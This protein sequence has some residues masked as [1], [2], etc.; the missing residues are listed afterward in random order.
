MPINTIKSRQPNLTPY[1]FPDSIP[2]R[3]AHL[4]ADM[5]GVS[6][7]G[8]VFTIPDISGRGRTF[9]RSLSVAV[10]Y[11]PNVVNGRGVIRTTN[12][13]RISCANFFDSAI[14]N[15]FT[16]V[17]V[18]KLTGS[19][20]GEP[21]WDGT[22][23]IWT[24]DG[25]VAT[26]EWIGAHLTNATKRVV[27]RDP[28]GSGNFQCFHQFFEGVLSGL[29]TYPS[30]SA[31]KQGQIN[32]R[33]VISSN[34]GNGAIGVAG[35]VL[36]LPRSGG[37]DWAELVFYNR[38]LTWRELFRLNVYFSRRYATPNVDDL[39]GC[40]IYLGNSTTQGYPAYASAGMV[41]RNPAIFNCGYSTG[42]IATMDSQEREVLE[43]IADF[44]RRGK[45]AVVVVHHGHNNA[46][47]GTTNP[48]TN[49][50][51]RHINGAD[52]STIFNNIR[53]SGA[54]LLLLTASPW[55]NFT[56]L[57]IGHSSTENTYRQAL[58][59]WITGS[60]VSGGFAD[61]VY[62]YGGTAEFGIFGEGATNV[63]ATGTS[64]GDFPTY[65]LDNVH[66]T[67]AGEQAKADLIAP[68]VQA[69]YDAA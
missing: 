41:S 32:F 5:S 66:Q 36:D 25:V 12:G 21:F 20:G 52:G 63:G 31:T 16:M 40:V 17:G 27:N 59:T 8:Q 42:T 50:I 11:E 14:S 15:N 19:D 29:T 30:A 6:G 56:N 10:T 43:I 26:Q 18:W 67:P 68:A 45:K 3:Y 65:W 54:K 9:T 37:L 46:Y 44:K 55:N 61:A 49:T 48:S 53:A 4:C 39:T 28:A 69:L 62:D 2:G 24:R 64:A 38:R 34:A 35:R 33:D 23:S 47:G 57:G 1:G 13:G 58:N 7:S 51:V 60:A 22:S